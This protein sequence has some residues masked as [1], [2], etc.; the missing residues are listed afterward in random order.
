MTLLEVLVGILIFSIGILG[1]VGL[2]ARAVQLSVDSEDRSRAALLANEIVSTMWTQ[3]TLTLPTATTDA[4]LARVQ[5]PTVSGLPSANG[6]VSAPDVNGVVTVTITWRS[7]AKIA[8][9]GDS[10]YSTRVVMP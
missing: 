9:D 4:W 7:P 8:A 5:D 6:T 10:T 2:Q 1:I 3:N